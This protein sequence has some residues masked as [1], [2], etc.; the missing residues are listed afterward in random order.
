MVTYSD[1]LDEQVSNH[2]QAQSRKDVNFDVNESK[3]VDGKVLKNYDDLSKEVDED[4][5]GSF[6]FHGSI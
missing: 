5:D 2:V 3:D 6:D 1:D 4:V